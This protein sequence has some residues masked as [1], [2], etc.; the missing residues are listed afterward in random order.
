M[1]MGLKTRGHPDCDN[2]C[3]SSP[4]VLVIICNV[5]LW[6]YIVTPD[7]RKFIQHS[8]KNIIT[9]DRIYYGAA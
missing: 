3:T 5:H 1:L 6:S 9:R 2:N 4:D 8:R 7:L